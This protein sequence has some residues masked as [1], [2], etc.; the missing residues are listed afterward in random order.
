MASAAAKNR[1]TVISLGLSAL[2]GEAP[3]VTDKGQYVEIAWTPEQYT[4]LSVK[5][6]ALMDKPSGEVRINALPIFMPYISKKAI[7]YA[8]GAI[9]GGFILGKII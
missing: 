6:A 8:I 5:F 9:G 4:R 3:S 1:A 7:P 2:I